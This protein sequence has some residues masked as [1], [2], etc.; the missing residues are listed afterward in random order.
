MPVRHTSDMAGRTTILLKITAPMLSLWDR[1]L[2]GIINICTVDDD[3]QPFNDPGGRLGYHGPPANPSSKGA[4]SRTDSPGW[5]SLYSASVIKSLR[6]ILASM[7]LSARMSMMALT[8][9]CMCMLEALAPNGNV[10]SQQ[11]A[12]CNWVHDS[13][14][15]RGSLLKFLYALDIS[16]VDM[17]ACLHVCPWASLLTNSWT[18]GRQCGLALP[19]TAFFMMNALTSAVLEKSDQLWSYVIQ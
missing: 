11:Y 16:T 18:V 19:H 4:P 12:P 2:R 17:Y 6:Y 7:P 10:T 14:Q 8:S 15:S 3:A 1:V 13:G 9:V 5:P